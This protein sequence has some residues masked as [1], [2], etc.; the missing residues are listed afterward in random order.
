MTQLLLALRALFFVLLLPGTVAVYIPFSILRAENLLRVP[1]L[2]PASVCA[3]VLTITGALVHLRCVWDFFAAGKG[4]LAPIDPPRFLVVRGLYRFTRNPM[5]NGVI[6][7]IPGRR[8]S[9]RASAWP[10]TPC[11]S[12]SSS[13]CSW[14]P[15]RSLSSSRSSGSRIG[16][17]GV[18]FPAGASRLGRFKRAPGEP[19]RA[20]TRIA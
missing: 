10:S 3:A 8:G 7:F 15:T 11:W 16:P 9:S 2:G 6:A 20:E 4:T 12:S 19:L 13:T 1:G 5:Y 14:S 18:P 17:T